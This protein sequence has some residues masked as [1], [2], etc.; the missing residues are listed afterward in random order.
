MRLSARGPLP[1][2]EVW[3]RYTQ[4]VW[5]P[6]W[7]PHLREVQYHE[8]VVKA[9]NTGRVTGVGGVVAAF[10]IE[11]VEEP[12]RTWAWSVRWGPLRVHFEHGVNI[13][14]SGSDQV[15]EAWLIMTAPWPVILG[16]APIARFS[17][18]RLVSH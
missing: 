5:W 6:Q 12:A 7:A 1:V 13:A 8:P 16:Y 18:G 15:S 4:P 3:E 10:R 9:G 14:S 17:L 2:N 11:T